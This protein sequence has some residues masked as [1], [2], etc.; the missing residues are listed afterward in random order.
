MN[1]GPIIIGGSGSSGSTLLVS[2]LGRHPDVATGTEL[3]LFNKRTFYE[4]SISDLKRRAEKI[5]RKGMCTD[6]WMLY[7]R[8]NFEKY[9]WTREEFVRLLHTSS[10]KKEITDRFFDRYLDAKGKRIW[11]EKT[12]SNAYCFNA[13][14]E[15]YPDARFIH[16][17][18]DG[19][20][21]VT[22]FLKRGMTPYFATMLWMYNTAHALRYKDLPEYYEIRYEDLVSDPENQIRK[23]CDFL[24]ISFFDFMLD[25]NAGETEIRLDSWTKSPGAAIDGSSVGSAESFLNRFHYYVLGHVRISLSHVKRYNL[26]QFHFFGIL[27]ELGYP[28][29]ESEICVPLKT[30]KCFYYRIRLR[31]MQ[32]HDM[33]TRYAMLIVKRSRIPPYPGKITLK[34]IR[35]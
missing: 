15:L 23:L 6:G 7:P 12:P 22:S 11:A 31:G 33:I 4:L 19:R 21:V 30:W 3:S 5:V 25:T 10:S 2:I 26:K 18:R 8:I 1:H 9:G 32:L 35:S 14:R 13:F 28:S 20:D 24:N 27:E 29:A 16:I 17:Y 34:R